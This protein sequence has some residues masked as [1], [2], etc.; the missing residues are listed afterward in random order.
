MARGSAARALRVMIAPWSL[1]TIRRSVLSGEIPTWWES[2]PPGAPRI[3]SHVAP[4]SRLRFTATFGTY[5]MSGFFGST[6][7]FSKYQPRPHNA[8]S[9][10]TRRQ[11]APASSERNTP[12]CPGGGAAGRP[13]AGGGGAGALGSGTRQGTTA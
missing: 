6:V 2:S 13:G 11:V 8:V 10:L 5:T 7:I 3:T 1:A 9:A 4:P 12:P